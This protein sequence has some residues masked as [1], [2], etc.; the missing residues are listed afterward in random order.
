MLPFIRI[1]FLEAPP[2]PPKKLSG[3]DI[4]RA[5]GQD[6]CKKVSALYIQIL[7]SCLNIRVGT[8]S[9]NIANIMTVGVYIFANFVINFSV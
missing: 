1:P 7:K 4:T 2:I 9:I 5:Q 3:T 8:A 6:T